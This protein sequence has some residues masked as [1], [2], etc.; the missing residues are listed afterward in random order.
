[1]NELEKALSKLLKH[2]EKQE[3]I[4]KQIQ[5][6]KALRHEIGTLPAVEDVK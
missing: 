6:L 4:I 5:L 1:M 2:E 3:I